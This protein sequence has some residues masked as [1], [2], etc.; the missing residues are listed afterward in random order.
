MKK[1]VIKI[2]L[3]IL[4][5]LLVTACGYRPSAKFSRDILGKK[6]STEV[7]ISLEDPQNTV[8]IRDAVDSAL[9]ET[10]QSSLTNRENSDTHLSIMMAN[11]TYQ[12]IQYDANGYIIAY[13]MIVNLTIT[14]F[15]EGKSKKYTSTGYYDFSVTPNA[16]ITDQERFDAIEF[17]ASKAIK[18]F[19][20]KL[21]AEGARSR[22]E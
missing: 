21:S 12:P 20:A 10:L 19:I 6:I 15:Q 3:A 14:K 1:V 7:M 9:A 8:L 18:S 17:G 13:R 5:I 22:K 11:P 16:I 2:V 4:V